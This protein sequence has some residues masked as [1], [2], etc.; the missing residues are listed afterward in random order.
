MVYKHHMARLEEIYLNR[1][2]IAEHTTMNEKDV[3]KKSFTPVAQ[4]FGINGECFR[5]HPYFI[6]KFTSPRL[7]ELYHGSFTSLKQRF[8]RNPSDTGERVIFGTNDAFV[9]SCECVD[10]M[11]HL[12]GLDVFITVASICYLGEA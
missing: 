4:L 6:L 5:S 9:R 3:Y 2:A 12:A 7:A 8:S 10:D 11:M 1:A